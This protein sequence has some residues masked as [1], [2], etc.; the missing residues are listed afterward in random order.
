MSKTYSQGPTYTFKMSP[1][2]KLW[3]SIFLILVLA[4]LAGLTDWPKGPEP[5]IGGIRREI[6]V[7][8]GLD[9]QGG[10]HLAYQADVSGIPNKD[11]ASA[12]AG[13]RD[14]VERRVNVFGVSEPVVQTAKVGE[15]WRV[16]VEL[17]GVTDVAQAIAMIG[18]TPLLEFKEFNPDAQVSLTPEQQKEINDYNQKAKE[19]A[20]AILNE[21]RQSPLS[22]A[23]IAREKS[24]DPGSKDKGGELG[25]FTKGMMVKE[26]EEA[27]FGPLKV[28]EISSDLIETQFGYHIVKK[29]DERENGKTS[30]FELDSAQKTAPGEKEV[31]ASHILIKTRSPYEY[32]KPQ[33]QWKYSGLTGKQLE[34]SQVSFD[35]NTGLPEVNIKFDNE[36]KDLFASLTE[37]NIGNKIGIFLDGLLISAPTVQEKIPSGNARISGT[38]SLKEAKDLAMRLNAGALPVPINLVSQQNIGPSLGKIAI[39]KSFLAGIIGII[40]VAFFM[41]IYYRLPG[42]LAVFALAIYGLIVLALFKLIPVTLTL[43]GVAGFILSIGMAVDAN[44]LIFERIKEEMRSGKPRD[45]AITEGFKRAWPSIRDGNFSTLITCLILWWFGTSVVKGFGLTLGLGVLMSMFSAVTIT[46]TF[47]KIFENSK[48]GFLWGV[49]EGIVEEEKQ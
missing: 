35:S 40:L 32:V 47:L 38:F 7:H 16:I 15:N 9:L 43:A 44:V 25:W 19:K 22:F 28:G 39:E 17:P 29:E 10:T 11:Q 13:V 12:V 14:V 45:L 34:K 49:K 21:V 24:D 23:E 6:K 18:E 3:W 33:D 26:F 5:I 31:K 4:I 2:A 27:V 46:R 48:S 41:I 42:I 36:G 37:K 1:R 8:L 20:Q 30:A